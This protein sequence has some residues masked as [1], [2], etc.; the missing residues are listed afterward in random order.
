MILYFND[1]Y[2]VTVSLMDL[3]ISA[4][5]IQIT[6]CVHIALDCVVYSDWFILPS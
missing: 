5:L 2:F 3:M 4:R 6:V 1:D